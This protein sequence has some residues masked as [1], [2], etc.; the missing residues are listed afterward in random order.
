[1]RHAVSKSLK[2][3]KP[4]EPSRC[5]SIA[6]TSVSG[7]S[8]SSMLPLRRDQ[9]LSPNEALQANCLQR[10]PL[11]HSRFRRPLLAL[12]VTKRGFAPINENG[13]V[14]SRRSSTVSFS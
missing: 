14:Y 11:R 8:G 7:L 2:D 10:P 4:S 1:M 3:S 5:S 12:A 9:E 6:M 13:V